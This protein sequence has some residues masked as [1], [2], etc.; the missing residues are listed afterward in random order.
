MQVNMHE[1]KSQL[2]LLTE[3]ALN[4]ETVVIAKA[5]KPLVKLVPYEQAIEHRVPGKFK[6]QV[7]IAADFNAPD[8]DIEKMFYG[9]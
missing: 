9:E 7:E 5:G 2:S 6:G 3:K 4:G 8:K 1:A